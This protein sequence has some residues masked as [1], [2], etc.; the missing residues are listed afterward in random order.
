MFSRVV[1]L[2]LIIIYIQSVKDMCIKPGT[3]KQIILNRIA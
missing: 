1:A 2:L 3:K